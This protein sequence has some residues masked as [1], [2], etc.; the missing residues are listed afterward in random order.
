MALIN[1]LD[2]SIAFG[3]HQ[4]LDDAA[5]H[6]EN[7]ERICLTG[8]N[9][10]GKSTLLRI[11]AGSLIPDRGER[12][13]APEVRASLVP[14]E[15]PADLSGSV[16]DV[17][18]TG[19]ASTAELLQRYH[20]LTTELAQADSGRQNQLLQK[21]DNYQR[22]LESQGAWQ[23]YGEI[24]RILSA[25]SL[26]GRADFNTLSGGLQRRVLL[27]RALVCDPHVLLLD[28][29]TNHL[30]I[31]AIT[32]LEDFLLRSSRT[33]VF[34]TH[35]RAFLRSLAT[36]IV[37]VD[38]GKLQSWRCG[39]DEY[40]RRR[41]EALDAQ[42]RQEELFDRKLSQ[43]EQW[44]RQGI[45]ARR[46]RN[47]GRVR[48]L[49]E[50]RRQKAQRRSAQGQARMRIQQ[51]ERS[52]N[53][54]LSAQGIAWSVNDTPI[55]RP[56]DIVIERGERIGLIGP[57][58]CGK[59]TLLRL[60]LGQLPPTSGS[61][62][63]GTNLQIAYFDQHRQILDPEKSVRFNVSEGVEMLDMGDHQRHVMGYLQD[64][65]FTPDRCHTP[66]KAL[67]GGERNRLLLAKLFAKPSNVLVLDEPTND[68]DM[69]TLELLEERL[70]EYKGTVLVV[71]HDRAFLNQVAT[72]TLAYEDGWFR[73]YV[74]GYDD[75][76]RQRPAPQ[77][78]AP[79]VSSTPP[80]TRPKPQKRSASLTIPE[81]RELE[82]LPATIE[83]LEEKQAQ[84]YERMS[85][86]AF[87]QQES[88]EIATVNTELE[89]VRQRLE[90]A[91]A[92]WEELEEKQEDR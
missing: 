88:Q 92:R 44:I 20:H 21:L 28:E 31:D 56:L 9:G 48:A 73:E 53:L 57:N 79:T 55:V 77:T 14:Q 45:K 43:E 65:L 25:M 69:E 58:G 13:V 29:P 74:G 86:P 89:E 23:F 11:L 36:R 84:C 16:W 51:G 87:Y 66:V 49:E 71:S 52:G 26:D 34:I 82:A 78:P 90:A 10:A 61:L 68:L 76:L 1:L 30:D 38:R 59:T 81:K 83:E 5:L 62:E 75:W 40:L 80:K 42:L 47:E 3:S 27:A 7:G 19:L 72:S 67:S 22:A 6:V 70:I 33:L 4:L 39:Y 24:D 85:D 60:L 32:W 35:D 2:I 8:R 17:V 64:F 18:A 37:E 91:Y 63:L 50:M 15:V 12:I 41:Q 46:T 54:V